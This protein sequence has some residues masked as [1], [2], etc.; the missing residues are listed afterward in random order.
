MQTKNSGGDVLARGG[1][2]ATFRPAE[3]V[4]DEKWNDIW[5]DYDPEAYKTK[6]FEDPNA[7]KDG[8]GYTVDELN[9]IEQDKLGSGDADLQA[10]GDA[11]SSIGAVEADEPTTR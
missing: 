6:K 1:S 7:T 3:G 8:K 4:S 10:S 5:A 2:R 11:G 9:R